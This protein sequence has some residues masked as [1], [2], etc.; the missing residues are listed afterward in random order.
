MQ[1]FTAIRF[2]S[3]GEV[4]AHDM[5]ADDVPGFVPWRIDVDYLP[6]QIAPIKPLIA[7][8]NFTTDKTH[9]DA[10]FRFGQVGIGDACEHPCVLNISN[11]KYKDFYAVCR[12]EFC[13]LWCHREIDMNSATPS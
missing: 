3:S 4:Y 2:I 10:A 9:W 13:P 6:V 8:L 11:S 12:F 7:Q 5:T 1:A